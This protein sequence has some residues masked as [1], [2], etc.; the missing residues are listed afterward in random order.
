MQAS[1]QREENK[2]HI[3]DCEFKLISLR[4]LLTVAHMAH[5]YK[6]DFLFT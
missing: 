4:V 1:L 3:S 5:S 2:I 6:N